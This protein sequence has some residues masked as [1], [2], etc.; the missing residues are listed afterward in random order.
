MLESISIYIYIYM[1]VCVHHFFVKIKNDYKTRCS[2]EHRPIMDHG[3][4]FLLFLTFPLQRKQ[5]Y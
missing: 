2:V 4:A 5:H 3:Q 1:C